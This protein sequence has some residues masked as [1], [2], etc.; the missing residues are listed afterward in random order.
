MIK[1]IT[2]YET[3]DKSRFESHRKAVEYEKLYERCNEIMKVRE[4]AVYILFEN[5][6]ETEK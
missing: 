4:E 2:I 3:T 6:D 5:L 1:E